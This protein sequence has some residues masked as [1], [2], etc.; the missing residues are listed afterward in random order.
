MR[1]FIIVHKY[2]QDDTVKEDEMGGVCRTRGMR[3]AI[4]RITGRKETIRK[5]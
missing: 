5:T 3:T 4:S 2:Y 1:S